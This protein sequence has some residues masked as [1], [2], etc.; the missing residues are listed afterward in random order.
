MAAFIPHIAAA[1]SAGLNYLG[2]RQANDA[3]IAE[4]QKNRDFQERMSNTA[5]QRGVED[6]KKAGINPILAYNQGGASSPSG[7][8]PSS[9]INAMS[10]AISSAAD[11]LRTAQDLELSQANIANLKTQNVNLAAQAAK[12][13]AEVRLVEAQRHDT[14]V[15]TAARI[16][17][18]KGGL[19]HDKYVLPGMKTEA[20]IDKSAYGQALRKIDRGAS[21]AVQIIE[22]I[23]N[24][25]IPWRA[26]RTHHTYDHRQDVYHHKA[27]SKD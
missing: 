20:A 5:Y 8:I 9:Q 10:P 7:G 13:G 22:M 25:V 21:T 19:L 24:A 23:K 3:N 1:A 14:A 26:K 4:A 18:T 17:N 12:I 16:A 27:N 15:S 6:M 11:A 2:A